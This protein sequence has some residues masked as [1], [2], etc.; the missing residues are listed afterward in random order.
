[1]WIGDEDLV[2][3]PGQGKNLIKLSIDIR[4]ILKLIFKI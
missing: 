4:I 3:K 2:G 1:M